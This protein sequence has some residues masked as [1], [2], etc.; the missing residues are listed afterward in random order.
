MIVFTVS[1]LGQSLLYLMQLGWW[2]W[3]ETSIIISQ[4]TGVSMSIHL[5]PTVFDGLPVFG[6]LFHFWPILPNLGG[7]DCFSKSI[8]HHAFNTASPIIDNS[9][10]IGMLLDEYE[11]IRLCYDY[12]QMLASPRRPTPR[13]TKH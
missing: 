8:W 1:T 9:R 10:E 6:S 11:Q 4:I 12:D 7:I 3:M 2:Q 13:Q 5:L